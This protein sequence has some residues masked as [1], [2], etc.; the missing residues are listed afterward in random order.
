MH[1]NLTNV[2]T[3]SIKACNS[4]GALQSLVILH[5]VHHDSFIMLGPALNSAR[6][7]NIFLTTAL[8][9]MDLTTSRPTHKSSANLMLLYV[10]VNKYM[11]TSS[12]ITY[13]VIYISPSSVLIAL[14]LTIHYKCE[15]MG[16]T[17]GNEKALKCQASAEF[18]KIIGNIWIENTFACICIR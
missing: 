10:R 7:L 16:V 9:F 11:I 5:A 8:N 15:D 4:A 17:Y 1:S 12:H 13:N 18:G 14:N 6:L 3:I 2:A